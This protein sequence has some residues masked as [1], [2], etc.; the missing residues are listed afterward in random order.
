M[1]AISVV[2]FVTGLI[3]LSCLLAIGSPMM[4]ASERQYGLAAS[5]DALKKLRADR[6]S[7]HSQLAELE[8]QKQELVQSIDSMRAELK[9]ATDKI[10]KMPKQTH[11]LTFELGVPDGGMQPFDFVLSRHA[12]YLDIEKI[13]GPERQLWKQPRVLRVWS[14]SQANAVTTAEKR[15]PVQNCFIVRTAERVAVAAERPAAQG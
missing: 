11:E 10:G 12:A 7:L 6:G 9:E 15:Y 14:R 1:F 13:S 2:V 3:G 4:R 5:R 8:S